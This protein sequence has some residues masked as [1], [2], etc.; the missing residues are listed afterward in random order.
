MISK[1]YVVTARSV[2]CA[3]T[4]EQAQLAVYARDPLDL[5]VVD[6]ADIAELTCV[7]D[8][9]KGWFKEQ[10]VL[11]AEV[12]ASAEE[13]DPWTTDSIEGILKRRN[14][15]VLAENHRIAELTKKI[16]LLEERIKALEKL[17]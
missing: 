17:S 2:V 14:D 6:E 9:P 7:E 3:K 5:F 15:P 11:D 16:A 8:I 10:C 1:L 12:S 4:I 13:A